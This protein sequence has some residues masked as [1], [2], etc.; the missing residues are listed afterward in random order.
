FL[1][2]SFQSLINI[3]FT[4]LNENCII[5]SSLLVPQKH[6]LGSVHWNESFEFVPTSYIHISSRLLVYSSPTLLC[7][8]PLIIEKQLCFSAV[9]LHFAAYRTL[10]FPHYLEKRLWYKDLLLLAYYGLL[11]IWL[12][13]P[14]LTALYLHEFVSYSQDPMQK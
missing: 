2:K 14:H 4:R 9:L 10:Q 11:K 8:F 7:D 5:N 12:S 6:L 13:L 3:A 1:C